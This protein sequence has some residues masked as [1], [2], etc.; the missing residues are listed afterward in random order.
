MRRPHTKEKIMN[1]TFHALIAATAASGVLAVSGM[2]AVLESHM[3]TQSPE[4]RALVLRSE[5]MNQMYG[6]GNS[7]VFDSH[8]RSAV[9]ATQ[10]AARSSSGGGFDWT[11]A[12]IGAGTGVA[13]ALIALGAF[14]TRQRRSPAYPVIG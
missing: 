12:G 14:A 10:A 11:D 2:A 5:G 4:M 3:T 8:D 13:A 6:L 9:V 1:R 7:P